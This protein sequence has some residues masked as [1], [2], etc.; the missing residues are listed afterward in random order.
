MVGNPI[1]QA[2]L[3]LPNDGVVDKDSSGTLL[4]RCSYA[5]GLQTIRL[6]DAK[7]DEPPLV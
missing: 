1:D 5:L 6:Q 2:Q 7:S 4:D 3:G